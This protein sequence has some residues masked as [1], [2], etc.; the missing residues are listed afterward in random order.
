MLTLRNFTIKDVETRDVLFEVHGDDDKRTI[1][2]DSGSTDFSQLNGQT[3]NVA[4]FPKP[5]WFFEYN[6]D[7]RLFLWKGVSVKI[8]GE[9]RD[10]IIET[11]DV[12]GIGLKVVQEPM[13]CRDHLFPGSCIVAVDQQPLLGKVSAQR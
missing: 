11:N 4:L 7:G 8:P 10:I 2:F 9:E 6:A 3:L 1:T 5:G 12:D 13:I